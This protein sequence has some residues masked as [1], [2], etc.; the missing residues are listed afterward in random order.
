M[1]FNYLREQ[2]GFIPKCR[3][4]RENQLDLFGALLERLV[5]YLLHLLVRR[6][7]IGFTD[8][9]QNSCGIERRD[10]RG[11]DI[12]S[13]QIAHLRFRNA[14]DAIHRR[15]HLAEVQIPLRFFDRR[16]QSLNLRLV[17][18]VQLRLVRVFLCG[19]YFFPNSLSARALSAAAARAAALPSSSSLL[20]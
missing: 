19:N 15:R 17:G 14:D 2:S 16:L 9:K 10:A 12:V 11:Q 20:A 1:R 5:Q 4:I 3:S 7:V 13:N 8:R 18:F 6:E